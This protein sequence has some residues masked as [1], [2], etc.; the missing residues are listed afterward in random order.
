[1]VAF[2]TVGPTERNEMLLLCRFSLTYLSW[3]SN[4]PLMAFC[5]D[6]SDVTSNPKSVPL[7]MFPPPVTLPFV[8]LATVAGSDITPEVGLLSNGPLSVI[9]NVITFPCTISGTATHVPP[10]S[11]KYWECG[12]SDTGDVIDTV[13]EVAGANPVMDHEKNPIG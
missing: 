13:V 1:M 4:V 6:I 2:D 9:V 3:Y 12:L 8:G 7:P 10:I 11:L 5:F